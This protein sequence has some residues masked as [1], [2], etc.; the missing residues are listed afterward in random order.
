MDVPELILS[1]GKHLLRQDL[2]RCILVCKSW[3][4]VLAPLIY[5]TV[6]DLGQGKRP[7][8]RAVER[9]GQHI[10]SLH[11][12]MEDFRRVTLYRGSFRSH[13]CHNLQ[14]LVL[15]VHKNAEDPHQE[16]YIADMVMRN[17]GLLRLVV[18]GNDV[19]LYSWRTWSSIL[20]EHGLA[21]RDISFHKVCLSRESMA[22]I[23]AFGPRLCKLELIACEKETTL[24]DPI[25]FTSNP[26]FPNL[27]EFSMDDF[28][29][30]FDL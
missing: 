25:L 24:D 19:L 27:T 22:A 26:Q 14:E 15:Y 30:V 4:R 28:G 8:V 10:R 13:R 18:N 3:H 9:Y 1:F 21:L 2:T 23:F 12:S 11:L 6:Q 5:H 20:L 7:S 29:G 17:A 16:W